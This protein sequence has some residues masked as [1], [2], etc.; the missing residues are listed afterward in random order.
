[1]DGAAPPPAIIGTVE[2]RFF[3]IRDFRLT[4]GETLPEAVI[5]YETYGRLAPDGRN[6]VLLTHGF[7]GSHHFA[8]PQPGERQPAGLMG[9]RW[10]ARARR[11]TPTS[12]LSSPRTCSAR[13]S[14]RPTRRAAIRR[15]ASPTAPIFPNITIRDIVA[16]QKALLD[17]LGVKHL[18][19]VAGPSYGGY[20]GFQ[21]AVAYPDFMDGIVAVNTAPW[22]SVNTDKQ[23]AEVT[24]KLASR[25]GVAW[26]PLL[27]QGRRQD[28]R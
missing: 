2:D 8:G 21:W 24:A 22:A 4:H 26:R 1:M 17:S 16:A 11:S 3:T 10:S 7:T 15:P 25:P 13:R 14:A 28:A 5:A 9:R 27:R 18:V 6:A 12:S 23:L 20:Q 19:A